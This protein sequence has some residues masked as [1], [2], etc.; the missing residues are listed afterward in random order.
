MVIVICK[1]D[2]IEAET[3]GTRWIGSE[4]QLVEVKVSLI[5]WKEVGLAAVFRPFP[6]FINLREGLN[7][8]LEC[9]LPSPQPSSAS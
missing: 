7:V 5:F 4:G 1:I 2:D 8:Q 3:L 6:G 9:F